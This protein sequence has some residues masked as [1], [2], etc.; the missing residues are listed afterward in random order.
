[1]AIPGN[2]ETISEPFYIFKYPLL[3]A[4]WARIALNEQKYMQ[5]GKKATFP[6]TGSYYDKDNGD[7]NPEN[8]A[9]FLEKLN[10]KNRPS[11]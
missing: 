7:R 3:N 5:T 1:M 2:T 11:V 4:Q 9:W 8:I 10:K 6:Y